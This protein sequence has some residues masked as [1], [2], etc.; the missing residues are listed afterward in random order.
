MYKLYR[1]FK[2]SFVTCSG[3]C[4]R[5]MKK[6]T[7]LHVNF[8]LG[9]GTNC[10]IGKHLFKVNIR[11]TGTRWC[12][13]LTTKTPERCHWRPLKTHF[14][15]FFSCFYCWLWTRKYYRNIDINFAEHLDRGYWATFRNDFFRWCFL[16]TELS[17]FCTNT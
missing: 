13:K 7:E 4:Q 3:S 8:N 1:A 17:K 15:P 6:K 12:L 5:G 16:E 11:N 2:K 14:R 10:V 9:L